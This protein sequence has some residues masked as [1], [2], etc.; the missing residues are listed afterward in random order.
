MVNGAFNRDDDGFLPLIDPTYLVPRM[1]GQSCG[2]DRVTNDNIFY[3]PGF[4]PGF[5]V[6]MSF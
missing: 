1:Y 6:G 5:H 2:R 3:H 4:R